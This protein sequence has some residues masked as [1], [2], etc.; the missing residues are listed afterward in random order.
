[1][2][3]TALNSNKLIFINNNIEVKPTVIKLARAE[4]LKN[5]IIKK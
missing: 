5:L 3:I 4:T 1:M 2:T